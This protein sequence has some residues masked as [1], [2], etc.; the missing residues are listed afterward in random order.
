MRAF[1]V[2]VVNLPCNNLMLISYVKLDHMLCSTFADKYSKIKYNFFFF[3]G[4]TVQ[5]LQQA[6]KNNSRS[7]E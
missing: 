7:F 5:L 1:L 2:K 4:G 3:T 6:E